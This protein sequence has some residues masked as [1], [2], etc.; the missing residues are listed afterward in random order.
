[1]SIAC[2]ILLVIAAVT[3]I[4]MT[5]RDGWTV[6]DLALVRRILI[7]YFSAIVVVLSILAIRYRLI[8]H[9]AK[10]SRFDL[11]PSCLYPIDGLPDEHRCPECGAAYDRESCRRLWRTWLRDT[12]FRV[13]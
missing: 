6:P 10:K 12:E 4:F 2:S 13:N 11:C 5:W 1:M 9:R 3:A 7:A 8:R